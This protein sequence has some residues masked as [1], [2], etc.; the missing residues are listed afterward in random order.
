MYRILE[1]ADNKSFSKVYVDNDIIVPEPYKELYRQ[2]GISHVL[3]RYDHYDIENINLISFSLFENKKNVAFDEVNEYSIVMAKLLSSKGYDVYFKDKFIYTFLKQNERIHIVENFDFFDKNDT[4]FVKDNDDMFM[5]T[6]N[7]TLNYILAFHNMF[8]MQ[9]FVD[10]DIKNVKYIKIKIS[11]I[12]GIGII[13]IYLKKLSNLFLK[14][15]IKVVLDPSGTRF[16]KEFLS[17][18][19][20][21]D[22]NP[23]D[24]TDSNTIYLNDISRIMLTYDYIKS[25]DKYSYD[26]FSDKFITD[27]EDFLH[28]T[29]GDNKALGL[30][31]RGTDYISTNALSEKRMSTLDELL[32]LIEKWMSDDKYEAVFLATEDEDV[33]IKL[34][35][36]YKE[37]LY[38]VEQKRFKASEFKEGQTIADREKE[39]YSAS[40]YQKNVDDTTIKYLTALYALS[41]CEAFICSGMCNGYQVV[42]SLN[43]GRFY[44]EYMYK[45]ET[46]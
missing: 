32:P 36:I 41:K 10:K 37:K 27:C 44:K 43:A 34:K 2:V 6:D 1:N 25:D 21:Y 3:P 33:L 40:E 22:F 19:F 8:Y 28:K 20:S 5:T 24:M 14:Y 38:Y 7:N 31:I 46:S 45:G 26:I 42:K 39:K 16:S 13:P 18:V 17:K 30:L 9:D 15:S 4:C 23:D 11:S 12:N 35:N 29:I